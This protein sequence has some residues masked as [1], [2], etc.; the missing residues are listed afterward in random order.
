M[1]RFY[2]NSFVGF[3]LLG[4]LTGCS[5][6]ESDV[7][8][9]NADQQLYPEQEGWESTLMLTKNGQNQAVVQYGHMVKYPE[10]ET[11]YL[12]EGVE[13]DFYNA[14]GLHTSNLKS[15]KA[16]YHDKTQDV[17]ALGHVVVVSDS[18]VTLKSAELKWDSQIE[19]I[20][21]DSLVMLITEQ[22]DTLFGKGFMAES[23]LSRRVI[24]EPWG[25]TNRSIDFGKFEEAFE[26]PK[27]MKDTMNTVQ[28]TL[29]EAFDASTE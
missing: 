6:D 9:V 27:T 12:D 16:E 28:D 25:V 21:S 7:G 13:V 29:T 1:N 2:I 20:L 18:G 17:K 4:L 14:D 11:I 5:R 10:D 3:I 23:D 8:L 15:Q 24:R 26:R 19:K 22:Q